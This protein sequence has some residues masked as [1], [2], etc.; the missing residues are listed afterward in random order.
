MNLSKI[1][2]GASG[3]AIA[4]SVLTFSGSILGSTTFVPSAEANVLCNCVLYAKQQVPS[5][6]TGLWTLQDKIR[7]INSRQPSVGAVA[8]IDNKVNRWGHVAVVR[9]INPNGTI[10]IQESNWGGCGIRF[11]TNTPARLNILGY[12]KP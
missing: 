6:P 1:I 5:L 2:S 11:R 10:T 9:K 8:I 4:L 3:G 7:I 12:F